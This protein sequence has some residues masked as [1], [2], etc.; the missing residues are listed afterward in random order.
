MKHL[1]GALDGG[2]FA[3]ARGHSD[4]KLNTRCELAQIHRER[5]CIVR[6]LQQHQAIAARARVDVATFG[7]SEQREVGFDVRM[8]GPHRALQT[9]DGSRDVLDLNWRLPS[10]V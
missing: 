1:A 7:P 2:E 3:P 6:T 4:M 5:E 10:I 9:D 8:C